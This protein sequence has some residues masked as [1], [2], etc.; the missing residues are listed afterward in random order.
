MF[1]K[2]YFSIDADYAP[3]MTRDA[4]NRNARTWLGFY[5]HKTFVD[6]LTNL[7]ESLDGGHRS[8]WLVGPYG[9]GKSHAALV[10]QKL[11]MDD[12]SRVKEWLDKQRERVPSV[13]GEALMKQRAANTLV[14]FD[15]GTA[16]I[17]SPEQLLVRMQNTIIDA[18]KER[19]GA[20]PVMGD[21]NKIVARIEE[22]E[23]A[24]FRK[25]DEIQGRLSY[26]T[27]DIETI[28]DLK[29]RL[30]NKDLTSG[31]VSDIMTVLQARSIYLNLS[32]SNLVAWVKETLAANGISK[33]VFIWDEFSTYLEQNRSELKTFEEI[34]E[35]TQEGQFFFMPVT[36]M[37]LTAYMAAGSDSAKKANDRFK[38]CQLDMPTNTALVLAAN[39][40][41]T[42][43]AA[44]G[45][46]R[47]KLWHDIQMVVQNYMANLDKDCQSNP[48]AFKG[49]LPIHPM[50]AF[51][52]KFLSTAVGSNQRSMFNYLKGDVGTS[53]FQ[54]FIAEGGPDI[55][56]R[57][58]LT[59]DYLWRY[60]IERS[61]LGL[62]HEISDVKAE[63]SAKAQGLKEIEQRVF[64]AVLLFS[65]LGR[66]TNNIGNSLIQPT[67]ENIV[68]SFEGDGV[69]NNVRA[70]L[71]ELEKKH[72][73]S[74]INNRCETFHASSDNADLQKKIEQYDLQFNEQF[75]VPKAQPK[76]ASKL[77]TFKDKLHFEVRAA[78]P[79]K[80][81][82][83]CQKQ[84]EA[85]GPDG[86]KILL[87]FIIAKDQG[88][89]LLVVQRAKDLA[90]QM[91]D[92]RMLFVT[93][94]ELHFCSLKLT[95]WK[96][97]VEQLAHKELA[98]DQAAKTNYETQLKLMDGEWLNKLVNN[99]QHLQ[100]F[101]PSANGGEPYVEDRQWNTME[102]L[103]KR[104]IGQTFESF[105]DTYS[106]YNVSSMQ[107]GGKGLQAWAKAGIDRATAQGAM[108][109][110]WVAFDRAGIT[111][112]EAWFDANPSHPL[113]KLRDYCKQ[114]L[115]NAINGSTGTCSIRKILIDLKR[116]PFGL[117]YVPYTAFVMGI[118]MRDWLNNPRQQLQ[119]TNG[120]MSDRLDIEALSEMIEASVRD[121]GNNSIKNEKLICRL[122]KEEKVFIDRAS[123]M[124]GTPRI[125]NATVEATLQEIA[126][127]LEK[128]SDRAPLW[129][130]PDYIEQNN[131]PS[132]PV[133]REII[134]NLCA[135]EKISSKGDQ[136]ER[137]RC[138]K[139]IGELLTMHEGVD[140]ALRK[141]ID[142]GVFT[143]AFKQHVDNTCPKLPEL[144]MQVGDTSNLYCKTAKESL[145]TTASWLWNVQNV[146]GELELVSEQYQV[147]A[148]MQNLLAS[149]AFM[150]YVDAIARLR[151]AMYEENKVSIA[152]LAG[153]YPFLVGFEN[154]MAN[155]NVG[156]GMK[157]FAALFAAHLESLRTLFFNPAHEVQ[158]EMIKKHFPAQISTLSDA[159][160]KAL[161]AKL[162]C[163]ARR[164][165]DDFK[166]T[167][168]S[169]IEEYIKESTTGQLS[170]LWRAKTGSATPDEWATIYR[171]PVRILFMN[172]EDANMI[173]PVVANPSVY[174]ADMLKKAKTRFEKV[175][176]VDIG[177][178]DQAFADMYVPLKYKALNIDISALCSHLAVALCDNPNQWEATGPR[179]RRA[180]AEFAKARYT[181]VFMDKA[182]ERVKQLTDTEMR[183]QLMKLVEENPE[184]GM[185]LLA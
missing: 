20:I 63:F 11:F 29:R 34:A 178:I 157:E 14:V 80:A 4:I 108:R 128:V 33:L 171:R 122:S 91:K 9:T 56:G 147:I 182:K 25:R 164:T 137:T 51:V 37:N 176:L 139:R 66:L 151:K 177:K 98:G 7:L 62:S 50:A 44:W 146:D 90:K 83:V 111:A 141:Y 82:A 65:L 179:F 168:L 6:I 119:W 117:L 169:E 110:V 148:L 85:F 116:P 30:G 97:Y 70:I 60:F 118:A 183:G 45:D 180:I 185:G 32:A 184:V 150:S 8:L 3:C 172:A 140:E 12:E 96:E 93:V 156:N 123:V 175:K 113:A 23:A 16:G 28:A 143:N 55:Q 114:K 154:L 18:I 58:F 19:H 43:N 100:V 49:I 145:A 103:L 160:L 162:S 86:N 149:K 138:I 174:Q 142:A 120:A 35:A 152:I 88:Q 124:F 38:F 17:R 69:V 61:D 163:G 54:R 84:K 94:P 79:D 161:Y 105:L 102:D 77:N 153:D 127:R 107:E 75:L 99:S 27:G 42:T 133:M 64:K 144:A 158:L 166:Q 126:D 76:L 41:K 13:V 10:L 68:R 39:A 72:C 48:T 74:I 26:L 53:E 155:T 71:E 52:L 170:Q 73:F 40:I 87:M 109:N 159:E 136:Q 167:V 92:F 95:N 101:L 115:T 132:A 130:L 134:D 46:E 81:L 31:L 165:A 129:V 89:Q 2:D 5:P 135:A 1:Y 22:E 78:T 67:V 59:V 181:Q 104:Y 125:V 131:E 112:D 121:A 21:L 24:F 173:M 106:G 36:H 47:D 57:Q 15:S